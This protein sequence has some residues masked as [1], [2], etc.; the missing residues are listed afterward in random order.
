M[1][2]AQTLRAI[3]RDVQLALDGA[4]GAQAAAG[5]LLARINAGTAVENADTLRDV[6]TAAQVVFARAVYGGEGG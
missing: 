5:R 1:S 4:G 6:L 2:R 3:E